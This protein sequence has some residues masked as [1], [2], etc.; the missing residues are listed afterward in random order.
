MLCQLRTQNRN[1][2]TVCPLFGHKGGKLPAFSLYS[3]VALSEPQSEWAWVP[4]QNPSASEDLLNL[5]MQAE[6]SKRTGKS[7]SSVRSHFC[8]PC[9]LMLSVIVLFI[10]L[11]I[12][13]CLIS[14]WSIVHLHCC[15]S[16]R[17]TGKSFSYTY[18][19]IYSFSYSFPI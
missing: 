10:F 13:K 7:G 6:K 2:T 4:A 17:C 3:F 8:V 18:I 9:Y 11:I 12:L 1:K 15:V 19:Y 16:L 5:H 14:Y